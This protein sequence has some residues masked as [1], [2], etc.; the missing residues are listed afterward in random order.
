MRPD[1]DVASRPYTRRAERRASR[2]H[3]PWVA[4]RGALALGILFA[5][6]ACR[7]APTAHPAAT[8]VTT[9]ASVTDPKQVVARVNGAPLLRE[10]VALQLGGAANA[11][12]ALERAIDEELLAQEAVRRGFARDPS[13]AREQ[14]RA[15]ARRLITRDFIERLPPSAIP[16]RLVERAYAL[17]RTRYVHPELRELVH[18][19]AVADP[20]GDDAEHH[21]QARAVA[22]KALALA[23]ARAALS[24]AEFKALGE[25]LKATSAPIKLRVEEFTTAPGETI[26]PFSAA[27]FALAR[28]GQHSGVVRTDFGYHVIYLKA[29]TPPRNAALAEVEGEVRKRILA[30]ARR[31]VLDERLS[32]LRQRGPVVVDEAAVERALAPK[33]G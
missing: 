8:T 11:Q 3:R 23:G 2:R 10:D 25:R 22:R 20:K 27:A 26:A 28:P 31:V 4:P 21:R 14:R 18:I 6:P 12:R 33:G 24:A 17:N 32:E 29:I 13:I 19:L 9:R 5:L 16:R 30:D 7:P 1:L 15:L